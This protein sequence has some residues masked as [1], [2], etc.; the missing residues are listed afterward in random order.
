MFQFLPNNYR[1]K[2]KLLQFLFQTKH[3]L[4]VVQLGQLKKLVQIRLVHLLDPLD[5]LDLLDQLQMGQ[6]FLLA[7]LDQLLVNQP[8][9]VL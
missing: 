1:S 5:L 4:V 3:L 8:L 7:Q 9:L 6:C 2:H